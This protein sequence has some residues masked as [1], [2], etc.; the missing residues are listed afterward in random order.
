MRVCVLGNSH[1]ACLK[2]AWTELEAAH[3][4]VDVRFFASPAGGLASLELHDG[5]LTPSDPKVVDHI[6]ITSGG[7][8]AIRLDD[9]D[10]F[11]VHALTLVVP[12]LPK[13][14]SS[15]VIRL[16]VAN[17]METSINLRICRMIAA[18]TSRPIYAGHTPI[19][20]VAVDPE[21]VPYDQI[22][23]AMKAVLAGQGVTLVPQPMETVALPLSTKE[24]Y[25]RG[26][27]KLEFAPEEKALHDAG[28][29]LHMNAAFGR[30]LFG[31]FLSMLPAAPAAAR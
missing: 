30:L 19:Q 18:A 14:L 3:P 6:R 24:E 1:V 17:K 9:F 22:A 5:Y 10:A 7:L 25:A 16:S 23:E 20:A 26:S 8:E 12:R 28:E 15:A 29:P 2:Q 21:T 13:H 4:G 27:R 11:F 31:S